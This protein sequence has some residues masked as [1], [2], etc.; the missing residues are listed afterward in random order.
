MSLQVSFILIS[1]CAATA[2]CA[3]FLENGGTRMCTLNRVGYNKVGAAVAPV[4]RKVCRQVVPTALGDQVE[5]DEESAGK[6]SEN[7]NVKSEINQLRRAIIQ[8]I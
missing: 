6:E 3:V 1:F 8:R 5:D 7:K 4:Y 2:F